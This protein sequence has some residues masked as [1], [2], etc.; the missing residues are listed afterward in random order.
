MASE[1][2]GQVDTWIVVPCF[3]EVDRLHPELFDAFVERQSTPVGFVFVEDGS[4]DGTGDILRRLCAGHPTRLRLEVLD[5]NQ[6]KAE[7]VRRGLSSVLADQ[8]RFVGYWDADLSAPL[9]E[10]DA[11]RNV[12]IRRLEI[13]VV[14]GIRHPLLGHRIRH[15]RL[16][17]Q[18]GRLFAVAASCTLGARFRDTQSG[19]KLFRVTSTFRQALATPFRSRWIFDIE[20]LLRCRSEPAAQGGRCGAMHEYPLE[21]WIGRERS[22]LKSWSYAWSAVELLEIYVRDRIGTA[23]VTEGHT[24][25]RR[26]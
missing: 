22:K 18:L 19:A 13:D 1:K 14:L 21:T 17:Q 15:G 3:N 2:T 6:G 8:P 24:G 23:D 25:T 12:L 9:N 16:R 5:S 7:A 20:L 4:T 11:L 26:E 10:I